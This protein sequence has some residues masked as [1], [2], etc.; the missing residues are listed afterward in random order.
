M[1][2]GCGRSCESPATY[3]HC[4]PEGATSVVEDTFVN[5]RNYLWLKVTTLISAGLGV[6]FLIH[7]PIG[8]KHGGTFYGYAVGIFS[9]LAILYLAWFGIRKRSYHSDGSTVKGC[10][11]VHIWVGV[12]VVWWALLHCAFRF[13]FNFHTLVFMIMVVV[14]ASGVWGLFLY[15]RLPLETA[16]NRG[17]RSQRALAGELYRCTEAIQAA[18]AHTGQATRKLVEELEPPKVPLRLFREPEQ[19]ILDQRKAQGLL[20]GVPI[21]ERDAA[22]ALIGLLD[23]KYDVSFQLAR[24]G[25]VLGFL[26]LWLYFHLPMTVALIVALAIHILSVLYYR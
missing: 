4:E 16:S 7:D 1:P 17:G 14:V 22:L 20:A 13:H 18:L 8:G 21:E 15:R 19:F 12:W 2:D 10:L 23:K 25:R 26:K 11:A 3:L 9:A 24:E 5:Y 6:W